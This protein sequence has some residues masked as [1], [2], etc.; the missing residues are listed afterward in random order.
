MESAGDPSPSRFRFLLR[1]AFVVAAARDHLDEDEDEDAAA[2]AASSS[3]S[4][5]RLLLHLPWPLR[6]GVLCVRMRLALLLCDCGVGPA[7]LP[8]SSCRGQ[9]ISSSG[10]TPHQPPDLHRTATTGT[11]CHVGCHVTYSFSYRVFVSSSAVTCRVELFLL[12]QLVLW[13]WLDFP[14]FTWTPVGAPSIP[15]DIYNN[16][17]RSLVQ[18][19]LV[20]TTAHTTTDAG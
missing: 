14:A 1:S 13:R 3:S 15:G 19:A 20:G 10:K 2:A 8:P 9:V 6:C 16:I 12:L 18:A 7:S 17:L 11:S 4:R 5:S